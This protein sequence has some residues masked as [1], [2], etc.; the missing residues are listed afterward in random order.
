[1]IPLRRLRK[2]ETSIM[3]SIRRI[4]VAIK[5]TQTRPAFLMNKVAP[6]AKGLGAQVELFHAE[7]APIYAAA[8][9]FAQDRLKQLENDVRAR[10]LAELEAIAKSL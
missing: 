9:D 5:D 3:R 6:L 2:Q 10:S 4:L 1:M 7:T 8:Y